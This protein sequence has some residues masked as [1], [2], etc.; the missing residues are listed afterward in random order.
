MSSSPPVGTGVIHQLLELESPDDY[1][2]SA[3]WLPGSPSNACLAVG[4]STGAVSLWDAD[5]LKRIRVMQGHTDRVGCLAW[6][7]VR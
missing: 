7:Q 3:R 5:R 2:S 4:D 6:N 1:V